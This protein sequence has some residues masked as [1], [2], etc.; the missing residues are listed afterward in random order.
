M[1]DCYIGNGGFS[2]TVSDTWNPALSATIA[3]MGCTLQSVQV[4]FVQNALTAA[5]I[6]GSLTLPF[7][8]EP[9]NVAISFGL[10]GNFTVAL[11][12]PSGV[13][14]L[15][16]PGLLSLA[17]NGIGF[18][19]TGGVSTVHVSGIVTPLFGG[20]DWPGFELR[21]LAIDSNGNVHL[22]GGWLDLPS[23]YSLD[24][25][26]F[27]ISITKLGFGKTNDGGK[28]I[29]FSGGLKLV[30]GL[31]AGASV[32]GLRITW[33]DDGRPPAITL[34]GVGV[35]FEIPDVLRFQGKV[36]YKEPSPG[37]HRFD[38]AIS[39]ELL[40]LDL[41]IDGTLVIG[42]APGYTFLA[43]YLDCEL[44]AGIPLWATGL[45]LYGLAGLFAMNMA[46]NRAPDQPWYEI[47]SSTDWF[48]SPQTGVVD[49]TTK[50]TNQ[51]GALAV[52]AGITLGTEPD[53]GF[54]FS[55]K[56][57]LVLSFPG[58]VLLI[59]GAANILK[60]RSSLDDNP[61]FRALVVLDFSA[62]DFL[63]G[64]D[65][66]YKV[67]DTGWLIDV[68][69][70]CEAY[71]ST[72]D[73]GAWH[74]YLG[75]K[76]PREKRIRAEIFKIYESDSYFMLDAHQLA[77]GAWVGYAKHWDFGPLSVS[78]EAWIDGNVVLSWKPVHLHGDLWLHGQA[79][80]SAF[81][82]GISLSVDAKFAADVFDPFDILAEF[83][84]SIDLPWP[85]PSPSADITLEFGPDQT[86]PPI[87]MPVKEIT[88]EHFKV[89]TSWPLP[90]TSSP[91]L[92]V[93]DY[94]ADADGFLDHYP[95]DT[96]PAAAAL[97]APPPGNAPVVP[98]DARPHITFGRN[99]H[100]LAPVGINAQPVVP[101]SERIG[102]PAQNQGPT[103]VR[104]S[105]VEVDLH[106]YDGAS[107]NL[108]ARAGVTANP[109]GV[110]ALYGSWA[111]MPS[112]PDGGGTN[113]GQVKLWLWS[114]SPFDYAS[115]ASSTWDEWFTSQYPDY[116]CIPAPPV[117][118]YCCDF[119]SVPVGTVLS[120]PFTCRTG[121]RI[122]W[123][124]DWARPVAQLSAPFEGLTHELCIAPPAQASFAEPSLT[125][126]TAP[127]ADYGAAGFGLEG[128]RVEIIPPEPVTEVVVT[129]PDVD[130]QRVPVYGLGVDAQGNQYGPF[131]SSGGI[132]TVTGDAMTVIVLT[133]RE[134]LCLARVC[135]IVGQS[136]QQAAQSQAMMQH[137]IDELVLWSQTGEVLE[138]NTDYRLTVVTK[139]E[140]SQNNIGPDSQVTEMAYF[141]TE[142]PPGLTTLSVPLTAKAAD[143][144]RSGLDDLTG[145][146]TQTVPS[147]VV[148]PG[149]RPA[150]PKPVYR[151][152]DVGVLFNEDYTDLMY[153][154]SG[155]DLAIYLYDVSNRPVRD[156]TGALIVLENR[157]G[158]ADQVT[159]TQSGQLWVNTVNTSTCASLDTSTIPYD[160][161]LAVAGAVLDPD[162]VYQAR[163]I[164]L[165]LH[166]TFSSFAAGTTAS[167]PSG[168]LGRW[169]VHDE[170]TI[171]GPSRWVTGSSGTPAVSYVEQTT[172]IYGGTTDGTDPVKPGTLLLYGDD[173]ALPAGDPAQPGNWTDYRMTAIVTSSDDDAIGLVFRYQGESTYYRFSMDRQ[174][175]YRRLVAVTFGVTTVLAEDDFAYQMNEDYVVTVEAVGS[176][177][178]IYQNGAPVFQITDAAIDHGRLGLYCWADQGARFADIRVDDFRAVAPVTYQFSF[179]TSAFTDA[180]DQAHDYQ[181]ETWLVSLP[182]ATDISA[183]VAAAVP[184]PSVPAPP[185]D[186][187]SRGY[188]ALAQAAFGQAA[189]A[190]PA[191]MEVSRLEQDGAPL[192]LLVRG[193]EP[194]D[195]SRT[196][197]AVAWSDR[198][199]PAVTVPGL[200]K[201]TDVS[202]S[203]GQPNEESVT[204][205]LRQAADPTGYQIE[206][207]TLP[208][209]LQQQAGGNTLLTDDFTGG[210]SGR[211][212]TE[213]FGPNALDHYTIVDSGT[214]LAP[215]HWE[216]S[217]S[218]ITQDS[219]IFGGSL[220]P[221]D[222][223]GS[224]AV[225]G[226]SGWTDVRVRGTARSTGG[227][228]LGMVFRFTDADNHYRLALDN[229]S[230]LASL[231]K[232]VGGAETVLWQQPFTFSIGQDYGF[233]V[234]A[235]R[236]RLIGY[237]DG[238]FLFDVNDPG[239]ASGRAG[240]Y[241]WADP[242]AVFSALTVDALE[243]APVRWQP[244][245]TSLADVSVVDAAGA[246]GSPSLW[247]AA[248]GTLSQ[249]SDITVPGIN[250]YQ[251]GTYAVGGD[252]AWTDVMISA[253]L[254]TSSGGAMGILFRYADEDNYLRLAF[255]SAPGL[256]WLIAKVAGTVVLRWAAAFT[257][258][259]GTSYDV[260]ITAC[261]GHVVA[262][263]NG[264]TLFDLL[265]GSQPNGM[266]GFYA[267]HNPGATFTNVR[268]VDIAQHLGR[269]TVQD[270][271]PAA[272][273]SVWAVSNNTLV[274]QATIGGPALPDA[275]GTVALAGDTTWTD[276]R[277]TVT[278]RSDSGQAIGVL[279]RWT[280]A[281]DYYRFSMDSSGSY[282]RLVKYSQGVFS[283]L[284]EDAVPF[285][286]GQDLSLV[287][288]AV[289]T[290][291]VGRLDGHALFD[292]TDAT[293]P[294]GMVGLYAWDNPS[295]R[296]ES[297]S[298]TLPPLDAYALFADSFGAGDFSAF[299]IVDEGTLLGPSSWFVDGGAL[300]QASEIYE[301][302]IDGATLSK[303]G[304]QAV[305]GDPA[306]TDVILDVELSST[307][308]SC[309]GVMIR[310]QGTGSYYRFSMDNV[311][312]YRRL[313]KNVGG[314]F[315]ALWQDQ[316]AYTPGQSYRITLSAI[317]PELRGYLDG[318]L[319]FAVTDTDIPSGRIALYDW[320][321]PTASFWHVRVYPAALA[322]SNWLLDEPFAGELTGWTIVDEGALGAPSAWSI[323]PVQGLVQTSSIS[324]GA[325]WAD[326]AKPG[327]EAVAGDGTWTD[328][329]LTVRLTSATDQAIGVIARYSDAGDYYRFSMDSAGGYRRLVRKQG[330]VVTILWQD[331]VAFQPGREY[332]LTLDLAGDRISGYVDGWPLFA[333]TDGTLP[334]G[335]VG[336]YAWNNPGAA[337]REVLVADLN[338][339][340]YY[341]FSDEAISPA[342]TKFR[343]FSG[344]ASAAPAATDN[345]SY[346]FAAELDDP[347]TVHFGT[348]SAALRLL[349][350]SG[351]VVHS[352]GFL[353]SYSPVPA[354]VLRRADGTAFAVLVPAAGKPG[355]ALTPGQYRLVLTYLRDNRAVAPTS[356]VLTENGSTDAEVAVLDIPWQPNSSR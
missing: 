84:V 186:A 72:S 320:G 28:W 317:G 260:T 342:G 168:T 294:A 162:T 251:P 268:V 60:E 177:I 65:M 151:A 140:T 92:L 299:T 264:Q 318:V 157:W 258:S 352:R 274:Q 42:S 119:E 46:P 209:P 215:S 304:T 203:S 198:T 49:L 220:G 38:G 340:G 145:Y 148:S 93:P 187:E 344:N 267:S 295:A 152:Y 125:A 1:T 147:T 331:G 172:N 105:L 210:P 81:G 138:P 243:S 127:S 273:P 22:D 181:D 31:S 111:P 325:T 163:L 197:P 106:S 297:V 271:V 99:V 144:F 280:S 253:T 207:L 40:V 282:R 225:T 326:P 270:Q 312:G 300:H 174:R 160:N 166:E 33:Y 85:L 281:G 108:V 91:A 63:V 62:G 223:P 97:A 175:G 293:N 118:E 132:L 179:T 347:G 272:A 171:S 191:T 196:T 292:V 314:T 199:A 120:V 57:L 134:G 23:Q 88:V 114:K 59:Q 71:F 5:S 224:V 37:V 4:T 302:P 228:G 327:T 252:L 8:D 298:V 142:G 343:V 11:S 16:K 169:T 158:H 291:L 287:I 102:D 90:R 188:E 67:D 249:A 130:G 12:D 9:L 76:D 311:R 6:S 288:D 324:G 329:R 80:L 176:A 126:T 26:G 182:A 286:A 242:G 222:R 240:F 284:W 35:E 336:L 159:L 87:P 70:S 277:T 334:T 213:G 259:P 244:A 237:L 200:A 153:R 246:S 15:T 89:T 333:V 78:V 231:V 52:G 173:P 135:C 265:D 34:N 32:D 315:T 308:G 234:L 255:E 241:V 346:R 7:F 129:L 332:V 110:P 51:G 154:L 66:E 18:A 245:F 58:P 316:M 98:L 310:Y 208:G 185:A 156:A 262:S 10:D 239:P 53:N 353:A 233:D 178:G 341:G 236:S 266:V 229:W 44:P 218:T 204:V 50:W 155:R 289:A 3:G 303:R 217:G 321:E 95:V 285:T 170:G 2:G 82:F 190:S 56:M 354:T 194:I 319:M 338:W 339:V 112:M 283:T 24:F 248:G 212:F 41:E 96:A 133:G 68:H 307:D 43:I 337:F 261:G 350:P 113:P 27:Q 256:A 13:L 219:W 141:R 351:A 107:W 232:V 238:A 20:L 193:P 206:Q 165:L 45:G 313:V 124:E 123:H 131:L 77:M 328:Y 64:L 47:N 263:V 250:A 296:F 183:S 355:T 48:H 192:G 17:V 29:G 83:S 121:I 184:L 278:L 104:Y 74:L 164:P 73:P 117:R 30:D 201:L 143:N 167:G 100:D 136:A 322:A 146:V 290:R 279:V 14:T 39:L 150:L 335:G 309:L 116:P 109:P 257:L 301:P 195:W 205:L 128:G 161:T 216:A 275:P 345:V 54:T 254:A 305:A 226:S 19:D 55:G 214:L 94:D 323:D 79:G 349:D 276:Y 149:E 230:G 306:W 330:G 122:L 69:G 21:D 247:S 61:L 348:D 356:Q 137:I 269:W 202:F 180:F 189:S 36:D 75:I 115:S 103:Q 235:Y 139:V 211:L 25:Y 101:D 221:G 227:F 86:S